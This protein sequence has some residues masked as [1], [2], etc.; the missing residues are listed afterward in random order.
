MSKTVGIVLRTKNREYFLRRALKS[1]LNQTFEDYHV[2]IINDGGEVDNLY[3]TFKEIDEKYKDRF[4]FMNLPSST[5][6]GSALSTGIS[7]CSEKYIHIHD[8]DDTIEP[9][10]LAKTVAFLEDDKEKIF[11]GVVTSNYDV[12]EYIENENIVITQTSDHAGKRNGTIID[13]ALYFSSM[14]SFVPIAVL[15]RRDVVKKV[16]N[17]NSSLKYMEDNEFFSRILQEGDI[18]IINDFLSSYHWREPSKDVNDV[19][20]QSRQECAYQKDLYQNNVIRDAINGKS[21]LKQFQAQALRDRKASDY[22]TAL[23]LARLEELAHSFVEMTNLLTELLK[24]A[25]F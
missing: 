13:C 19:P 5:G 11:S 10:F 15:F 4:S 3:K 6:R 2:Y 8:D 24:R 7:I 12:T 17:V 16:G 18:G 9:E 1:I 23:I 20:Q 22:E 14:I 21:L 25:K